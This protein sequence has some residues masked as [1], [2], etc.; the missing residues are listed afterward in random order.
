MNMDDQ[1]PGTPDPRTDSA[2]EAAMRRG[3]IALSPFFVVMSRFV[4]G[5]LTVI[6]LFLVAAGVASAVDGS[7]SGVVVAIVGA[8]LTG[9]GL[10]IFIGGPRY[11]RTVR[12]AHGADS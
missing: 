5:L 12:R 8:V 9:L 1:K 3:I 4:G 6:A 7:D 10:A 2:T 11:A